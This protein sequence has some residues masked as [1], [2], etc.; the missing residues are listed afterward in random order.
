MKVDN[1]AATYYLRSA[2][3]GGQV[4]AEINS[5]GSWTRGY[6]YASGQMIAVQAGGVNW[7]YQDP[8]TKS[9][10]VTDNSGNVISTVDLDP[11][12]GETAASSNQAF[13]PH[14]FTS[15]E[16]DGNSGDEAMMRRY[17]GKW[18][19]FDQPDPYEGSYDLTDPQSFNRY[20]YTQNDP[21]NFVDPT[22]LLPQM[23][24]L[25]YQG[26]GQ[27]NFVCFGTSDP[28]RGFNPKPGGGGQ[29]KPVPQKPA[30]KPNNQQQ[31]FDD[32][33]KKAWR[34]FRKGYLRDSVEAVGGGALVA[35]G[36]YITLRG[37]PGAGATGGVGVRAAVALGTKHG[38]DAM[39]HVAQAGYFGGLSLAALGS[40]L[41]IHSIKN[42]ESNHAQ[43]DA[44]LDDC[45]KRFPNANHARS[46]LNF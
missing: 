32:C 44:A 11:W 16:R 5:A 30:P 22:G 8:V 21:V 43:L 15:Y 9:Q 34:T 42:S 10:R 35:G 19:R 6:V 26:D 25:F 17:T 45:K 20:A 41:I 4:L 27:Y 1:G 24:G 36:I 29:K 7:V 14:R 39:L 33:A 12:G 38:F 18:H 28:F 2:V 23:C 13:Q 31:E 37:I 46:F 3:L 40:G